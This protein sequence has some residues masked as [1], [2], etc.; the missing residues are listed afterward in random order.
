MSD[1]KKRVAIVGG[2]SSLM[3]ALALALE[4]GGYSG[5]LL[6]RPKP[7]PAKPKPAKP[8]PAKPPTDADLARIDA[9][10]SKR[11]RR[12]ERNKGETRNE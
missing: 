6:N 1:D 5:T 9:A 12:I 2:R 3:G 8:K 10:E 4:H 11:Q 7:K